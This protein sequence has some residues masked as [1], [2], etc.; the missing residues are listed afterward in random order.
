MSALLVA[1]VAVIYAAVAVSQLRQGHY[2]DFIIWSG[3]VLANV[4]FVWKYLQ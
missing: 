3:Y 2:A 1:F 4:G